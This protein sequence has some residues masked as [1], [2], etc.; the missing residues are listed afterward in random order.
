MHVPAFSVF[1]AVSE[2]FVTAGV[3]Y[4]VRRNWTRRPFPLAVFLVVALFEALVNVMYMAN[5]AAQASTPGAVHLSGGMKLAFA[6]HGMLSLLAY[7]V[8]V[9]LAV[10]AY[11]DQ[12]RGRFFFREHP[13]VTWT[14]AVVWAVS[15]LSGET[16]FVTR[17][18]L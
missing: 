7:L 1:S 3:I 2:L 16:L 13:V 6:L 17:Y 4:V 5:R 9:V 18:L 14:F 12:R 15:I 10:F 11:Q 8:F